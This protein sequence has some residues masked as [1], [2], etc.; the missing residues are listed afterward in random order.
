MKLIPNWRKSWR[1]YSQQMS[2]A[3][4]GLQAVILMFPPAA[5]TKTVPLIARLGLAM[6]WVELSAWMTVAL[7]LINLVVRVIDQGDATKVDAQQEKPQ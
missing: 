7:G 2:A 3:I 5:L 4:A 1:M 6:T